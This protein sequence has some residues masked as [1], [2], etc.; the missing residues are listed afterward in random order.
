MYVASGTGLLCS[1]ASLGGHAQVETQVFTQEVF[2][3]VS[4]YFMLR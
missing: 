2:T 1:V 3:R 4:P